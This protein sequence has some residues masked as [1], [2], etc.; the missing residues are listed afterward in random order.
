MITISIIC[1]I[2]SKKKYIFASLH[3]IQL[4]FRSIHLLLCTRVFFQTHYEYEKNFHGG[5]MSEKKV[6]EADNEL[7][8]RYKNN[9]S[10]VAKS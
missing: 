1:H 4:N 7:S 2:E 5:K 9:Q 8:K 6:T 10:R 3:N